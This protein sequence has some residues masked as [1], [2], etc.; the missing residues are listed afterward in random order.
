M[1]AS[2]AKNCGRPPFADGAET[3]AC[4]FLSSTVV[5]GAD[6][7]SSR[8]ER[9]L[10]FCLS[11][12]PATIFLS[13]LAAFSRA[14]GKLGRIVSDYFELIRGYLDK[15]TAGKLSTP[16][17]THFCWRALES[18]LVTHHARRHGNFQLP[19]DRPFDQP[20]LS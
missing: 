15:F 2:N 8:T 12:A 16:M 9:S 20:P 6:S 10:S 14:R 13:T 18:A 1:F 3:H 19:R 4:L 11:V 7:R 5:S 17:W